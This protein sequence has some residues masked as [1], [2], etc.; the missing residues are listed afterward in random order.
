MEFIDVP[1][2]ASARLALLLAAAHA[3]AI[4]AVIAMPGAW[5][6]R[7]AGC[8]LLVASGT[9]LIRRSA[10]LKA[11]DS[12]VGLQLRR[13]GSCQLQLRNQRVISGWVC[14]GSIASPLMIVM[15]VAYPGQRIR[16]S[17]ALLPDAADTD[18][19]RRLRIFLRFAI[20]RSAR[21]K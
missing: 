2:R 20:E 15:Q 14:P 12:V 7:L 16:R 19:L 5:W 13:D 21:N 3:T 1:I 10:L 4:A 6:L 18:T 17:I 9:I 8:T 11:S